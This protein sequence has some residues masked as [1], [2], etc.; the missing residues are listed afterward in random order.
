[1]ALEDMGINMPEKAK[2]NLKKPSESI[3]IVLMSRLAEMTEEELKMLDEAISPRVMNV[4]IKLL[5]E[6][7]ELIQKIGGMSEKDMPEE[8]PKR[9]KMPEEN[10]GALANVK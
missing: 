4:L 2:E 5:P 7:A 9:R 10:M 6:L 1:M 8:E 3:Q